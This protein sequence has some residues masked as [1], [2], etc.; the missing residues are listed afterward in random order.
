MKKG[1][2]LIELLIVVI[3]IGVV[4]SLALTNIKQATKPTKAPTLQTLKSYL[5]SLSYKKE[6]KLLCLDE[7]R[8][9]D[10]F[11]DGKKIK[12]LHPLF[13][14]FIDD[15]VN[16]YQYDPILGF[17]KVEPGVYFNNEGVEENVCFSYKID[18]TGV[19]DQIFVEF[20]EKVYDF[21]TYFTPTQTYDSLADVSEA[22]ENLYQEVLR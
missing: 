4:Y 6:A 17:Q 10:V 7:C 22:K 13:E 21:T 18:K 16:T 15:S 8:E 12:K 3:I 1:F 9:C 2:T 11:L 19:G 5:L 14:N 20:Q